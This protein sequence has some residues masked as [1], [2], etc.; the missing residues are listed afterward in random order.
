MK[1]VASGH[2]G[3]NN[4]GGL[5]GDF[6]TVE[7]TFPAALAP[8]AATSVKVTYRMPVPGPSNFRLTVNGKSFSTLQEYP[9]AAKGSF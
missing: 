5:K 3:P 8:G 4:T 1:V 2:T 6:H 9:R 7:Y